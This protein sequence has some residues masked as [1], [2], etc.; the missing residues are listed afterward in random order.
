[1]TQA[2]LDGFKV[3]REALDLTSPMSE[4][5]TGKSLAAAGYDYAITVCQKL[6]TNQ[7]HYNNLATDMK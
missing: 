5:S 6:C 1:M 3:P 2:G 7:Q 4:N